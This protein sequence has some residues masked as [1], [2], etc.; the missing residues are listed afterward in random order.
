[1]GSPKGLLRLRDGRTLVER[2]RAALEAAGAEVV[3]V[4]RRDAYEGVG[5]PVVVDAEPDAGPLAGLVALLE[6]AG[7]RRAVALA[8]DM[9]FV[10]AGDLRTLLEAEGAIVAPRRDGRW[11]PLCAVYAPEVL[12]VA[13][14][15][16][17]EG[18]RSLTGLL[19]EVGAVEAAIDPDHLVDWD[20]PEDVSAS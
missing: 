12:P 3:L 10:T 13:R 8:C 11:E 2:A 18:R 5:L 1:M 7:G 20:A 9:P 6:R 19:E 16:L 17:G 4:G 14:R 15:R